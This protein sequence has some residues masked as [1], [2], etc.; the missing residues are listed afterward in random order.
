MSNFIITPKKTILLLII[1]ITVLQVTN[2]LPRTLAILSTSLYVNIKYSDREFEYQY[3]EYVP[4]F[5]DYFVT[6]KDKNGENISFTVTPK[7]FPVYV[8]YDPLDRPM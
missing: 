1:V 4:G 8:L 3:V 5:G 7:F 6:F 2:I